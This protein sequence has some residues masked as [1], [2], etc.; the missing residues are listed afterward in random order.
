MTASDAISLTLHLA[1]GTIVGTLYFGSLWWNA[2]LFAQAGR[3]RTLLAGMVA[4]LVLLGAVLT[5]ASVEGAL[6]LLATA[7]GVVLARAAVL[8]QVRATAS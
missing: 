7:L 5:A 3:V 8:R 2:R 6:P 4:R 1:G